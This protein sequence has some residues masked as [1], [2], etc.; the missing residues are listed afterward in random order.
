MDW[1][2]IWFAFGLTLFAGLSTGIG[3]AMAFFAKRTNTRFLSLA[4]GF[5]AGVMIYVSFVEI[6][7]KAREELTEFMGDKPGTWVTV[8]A[9]FGGMLLIGLIARFIPTGEN[10]HDIN[11]IENMPEEQ[12]AQ[13]K[14][15]KK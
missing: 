6:F 13:K 4:L 2:T 3:S 1:N 7:F 8:A 12:Q 10:P 9:F 15:E 14:H 5:S 11:L